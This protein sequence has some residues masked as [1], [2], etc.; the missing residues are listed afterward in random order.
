MNILGYLAAIL[1]RVSEGLYKWLWFNL[2]RSGAG[3]CRYNRWHQ[4]KFS[5]EKNELVEA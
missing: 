5:V 4:V 1:M 2:N 3:I